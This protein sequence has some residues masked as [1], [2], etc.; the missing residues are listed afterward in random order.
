MLEIFSVPNDLLLVVNDAVKISLA[1][2]LEL[3]LFFLELDFDK[4]F[5]ELK[6]LKC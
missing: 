6:N 1:F 4:S 5:V 3:L 2:L